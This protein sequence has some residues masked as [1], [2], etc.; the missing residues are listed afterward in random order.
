MHAGGINEALGGGA[1]G[2]MQKAFPSR[3]MQT[4]NV[5]SKEEKTRRDVFL[6]AF[7]RERP[8]HPAAATGS[9]VFKAVILLTE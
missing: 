1:C 5:V 9:R 3:A 2:G 7:W 8:P 6:E 4:E